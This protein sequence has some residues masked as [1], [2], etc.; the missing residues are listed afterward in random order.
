MKSWEAIRMDWALE[1]WALNF[2]LRNSMSLEH[3]I[4]LDKNVNSISCLKYASLFYK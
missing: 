3:G 4:L 2:V 1:M